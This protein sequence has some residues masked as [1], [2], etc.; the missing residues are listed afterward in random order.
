MKNNNYFPEI[1]FTKGV[2]ITLMVFFHVKYVGIFEIQFGYL[3]RFVYSFHMPGFLVISGFFINFNKS[4]QKFIIDNCRKIL[5]PFLIFEFLYISMLF[6]V[7]NFGVETSDRIDKYDIFSLCPHLFIQPIG[8]YW[9]LHTLIIC[10]MI[11]F[12]CHRIFGK[13]NNWLHIVIISSLIL[14]GLSCIIDGLKMSNI[15]FY[16]AGVMLKNYNC[17]FSLVVKPSLLSIIPVILIA[18]MILPALDCFSLSRVTITYL[19]LSFCLALF[20]I[21]FKSKERLFVFLGKNSLALVLFSPFF[22]AFAKLFLKY[23]VFIDSTGILYMFIVTITT[24]IGSLFVS[25]FCDKIKISTY[26]LAQES[27]QFE[28]IAQPNQNRFRFR[29]HIRYNEYSMRNDSL[30]LS[31]K[32]RILGFGDSVINGGTPTDQDSLATTII[33]NMLIDVNGW[34]RCLNISYGS[35]GPD[36]CYAYLKEYGDF[37]ANLIFLVVSSH[38]AYDTMDF[39]KVVDVH[40]S[41]PSKQYKSAIYELFDRYLIPRVIKNKKAE[42]DHITKGNVFNPGF[43]EFYNYTQEKNIPFFI[44][45]HPD[46]KEVQEGKYDNQGNTIIAFCIEYS[47][48]LIKGIEYENESLFRDGIHLNEHGQRVLAD[49]LLPEIEL[50]LNLH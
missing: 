17:Q 37:G 29:K 13:Y 9:Y 16:I 50:L 27:A 46:K 10:N 33:E 3:F 48:P 34:G 38:D 8:T 23:F 20:F 44:Y 36:N 45:L 18:Y 32:I 21:V 40:P 25:Y 7:Q 11:F 31:D 15:I 24:I 19:M 42:G 2:L 5:I 12:L 41:Y 43:L 1:D 49:A 35:W 22:T 47:V 39:G 14:Y 30:K 28:Y 6:F 26:V 4:S